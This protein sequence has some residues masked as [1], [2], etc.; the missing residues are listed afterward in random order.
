MTLMQIF[1]ILIIMNL[2]KL[3]KTLKNEP[4]YRIKQ[5]R[6]QIFGNLI[7]NWNE[8]TALSLELRQK[9]NK[10]CPLD[11]KAENLISKTK[12]NIK[13]R[14]TLEDGVK[15]E[16]I[17]MRHNDGRNTVCVSSEAGCPV[18]CKFCATGKMGF[19]RNLTAFEIVEQ[20]IYFARILK[21]EGVRVSNVVFMGMGEP[22]LNYDEVI[23]AIKILNKNLNIGARHISISTV[24]IIEGINKLAQEKLQINLAVSLHASEGKK[25][26]EI[27]KAVD[28]YILKTKRQV[29]FEYLLMK[30]VND[31]EEKAKEIAGLMKKPLYFVNL[32]LYNPTGDFKP[33]SAKTVERFKK[34]LDENK[35]KYSQRY[36]F[37]QDIQAACGQFAT[38]KSSNL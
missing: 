33:P 21:K 26:E 10:E 31:S 18:G 36:R 22:F 14:I 25:R 35:I 32:I 6:E 3:E 8:A 37:G 9:L 12:D 29:M 30:G 23:K 4:E 34:V 7:N 13:A 28:E 20:I 19:I 11:I 1:D 17:L 24:G 27:L 38:D 5:A 16:T 2:E 15:I